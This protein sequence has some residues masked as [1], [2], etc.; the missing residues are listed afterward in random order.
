MIIPEQRAAIERF[1]AA[2]T[3]L[4][5]Q[6]PERDGRWGERTFLAVSKLLMTLAGRE[7]GELA[8]EAKGG[9]YMA[10]LDDV[11][12]W[13]TEEAARLWYRGECGVQHNY[14]WPPA[15]AVLRGVARL[16]ECALRW[17]S[18]QL[19]Q[20]L[21]AEEDGCSAPVIVQHAFAIERNQARAGQAADG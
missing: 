19:H 4:L 14:T 9:A 11:P 16:P 3:E 12:Y 10:A 1:S 6:T 20:L 13:A 17:T 21:I 15:P 5:D 7:G 2:V 18:T 8:G